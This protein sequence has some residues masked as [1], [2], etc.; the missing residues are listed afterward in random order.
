VIETCQLEVAGAIFSRCIE[1]NASLQP[2]AKESVERLVP[3]YV[4]AAQERFSWCPDCQKVYWPATHHQ[5]M[6][7][8]LKK[9]GVS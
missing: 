8:E 5:R 2:R 3:S 4:F 9:M 7:E 1:C 6:L